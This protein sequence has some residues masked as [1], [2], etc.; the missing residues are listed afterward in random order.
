MGAFVLSLMKGGNFLIGYYY[1]TN[2]LDI[3]IINMTKASRTSLPPICEE[4]YNKELGH[5]VME[6][7]K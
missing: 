1:P 3:I 4:I 2:S 6:A 7:E 5:G